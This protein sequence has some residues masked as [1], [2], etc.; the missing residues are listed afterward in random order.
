MGADGVVPVS[1]PV[2]CGEG[3]GGEF[4]VADLDPFGVFGWVV[5][6]L[7]GEAAVG[8]G[9]GESS[10]RTSGGYVAPQP[11]T[12]RPQLMGIPHRKAW[13]SLILLGGLNLRLSNPRRRH[14]SA[15]IQCV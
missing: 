14:G 6:D 1:A 12:G 3:D 2:V 11:A 9:G 8:G 13:G 15:R 10:Y 4:G 7:D 5:G